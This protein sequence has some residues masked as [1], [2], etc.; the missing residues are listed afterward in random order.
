MGFLQKEIYVNFK[1]VGWIVVIVGVLS[2][3]LNL[4]FMN[5]PGG[6][7]DSPLF[8]IYGILSVIIVLIG[9]FILRKYRLKD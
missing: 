9:I 7:E 6:L 5:L 8:I 1:A 3:L 2:L 4:Y